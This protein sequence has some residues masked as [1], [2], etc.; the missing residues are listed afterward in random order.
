MPVN[1]VYRNLLKILT[2]AVLIVLASYIGRH[3]AQESQQQRISYY[4]PDTVYNL[5][6]VNANKWIVSGISTEKESY[7]YIGDG[8]GYNG[9]VSVLA[10]TDLDKIINNVIPIA[11]HETPSFFKKLEKDN[12]FKRISGKE[13]NSFLVN[14]SIDVVSGA[15]ISSIAVG[16]GIRNGY[17][18]GEG[19]PI[20]LSNYPVFGFLEFLVLFLLI[21]GFLITKI[22]S[23]KLQKYLLWSTMVLS[24]ILLGFV[25]NQHITL[26]RVS[27]ILN[28]YFPGINNEL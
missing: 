23:R 3:R 24:L 14:E 7:I 4:F 16:Q 21:T 9:R 5:E 8:L 10:Q 18:K 1:V 12:Y 22:K 27:A 17:S 19:I 26:S 25:Y 20:S 11:H 13:I 15:T 6:R 2:I 28:G